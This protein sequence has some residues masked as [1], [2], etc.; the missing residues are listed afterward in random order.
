MW[1][2]LLTA[3]G[4]IGSLVGVWAFVDTRRNQRIKLLAY[5]QT[6]PFPLATA[7][8]H[9]TDYELSIHYR[10]A[11]GAEEVIDAAF[12]SYLLFANFGKEPIRS[13]DIAPS[14]PFKIEIEN[15]R[16]LD[17]A[18]A[19]THRD[20]SS[21]SVNDIHLGEVSSARI[22]FDFLDFRDG[23]L[24]R[25]LSTSREAKLRLAGDIIGMPEGIS[26]SDEPMAK[27]PWGRIGFGLWLTAELATFGASAFLYRTVQGSWDNIWL[28]VLPFLAFLLPCF[29]ALVASETIWPTRVRSRPY[30]EELLPPR[31]F[32]FRGPDQMDPMFVAYPEFAALEDDEATPSK[33]REAETASSQ[34]AT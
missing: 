2:L 28:L 6:V 29:G 11:E 12:V 20:V 14:S 3:L 17:I 24:I 13:Q 30:P 26:R 18:L 10:G 22:N 9:T 32:R 8:G 15:A 16:V 5:E 21:I 33:G 4:V 25:V 34:A 27:G 1:A 19:G 31:R 7:R 23:G